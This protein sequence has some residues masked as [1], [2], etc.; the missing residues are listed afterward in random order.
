VRLLFL[1]RSFWPDI[2]ATGQL[3][4]ELCSDLAREHQVTVIAGPSYHRRVRQKGLITRDEF[5]GVSILRTWGTTLSKR[6]LLFRLVNLGTYYLLAALAAVR[7]PRP[8]I[9]I[10]ETDPPLLGL[11]AAGLQAR[12]RCRF[13][14][15]CQDLYPDIAR[16]TSGLRS[17]LLLALL[18]RANRVAYARADRIVVVGRDMQR[19]LIENGIPEH[20]IA[21]VPNWADCAALRAPA[22][23]ELRREFGDRFVVMYSGNVGLSQ[24]LDAVLQAAAQI[25]DE[26]ILF[27][28][29]GDGAGKVALQR[30]AAESRLTNVRFLPYQ[31]KERLGE[32]LA[33]ADLH[34]VPLRRG[35]A[36]CLVPSKVY[37]IL[38]A[39]RPFVAMMESDAE[40]ARIAREFGVGFV[41]PPGDPTALARLTVDCLSK[42]NELA[43]MG[44]RARQVAEAHFDRPI[45]SARFAALL[46]TVAHGG[47]GPGGE[48]AAPTGVK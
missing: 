40:V 44:T 46:A 10:A 3:L 36:G 24:D 45:A 18:A 17:P 39:G 48:H 43:E 6:R 15:Y 42:R 33:A 13:V 8:D 9:V 31:E 4:T 30:R 5:Q 20:K 41:I 1:N 19:R 23:N 38:A 14:Y 16:A 26:R 22:I 7:L 47:T 35:A 34:L 25:H 11:L 32:S 29:I 21:V 28:V 12:W 2:E 37:G 27:V